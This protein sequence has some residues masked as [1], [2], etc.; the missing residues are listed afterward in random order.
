ME[1]PKVLFLGLG[2]SPRNDIVPHM[3]GMA[4]ANITPIEV[5]AMDGLSPEQIEALVAVAGDETISTHLPGGA[6][7][8]LSKVRITARIQAIVGALTRDQFDIVVILATGLPGPF[9]CACPLLNGQHAV[10]SAIMSMVM[11][12]ESIGLIHPLQSQIGWLT[13]PCLN[14]YQP[15]ATFA[16]EGDRDS[17]G[18][19]VM[20]L[21]NSD[22]IVLHS[23]SFTESD[24]EVVARASRRPVILTRHILA[25]A[26]RLYLHTAPTQPTRS[27]A[28]ALHEKLSRLTLRER[29][30]LGLVCEG[31]SSKAIAQKLQISPKTV[32][33]H[34]SHVMTKMESPS[35]GALIRDVVTAERA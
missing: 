16:C 9:Y 21:A 17:L 1:S 12:G 10:E 3:I 13:A 4:D 28:F 27:D 25:S 31:L 15:E 8:V 24:R 5:G 22:A 30:I 11:H 7:I 19:A 23:I 6:Q 29:E 34:R 14:A 32:E 35:L 20:A 2:P 18:R 26:I 33:A